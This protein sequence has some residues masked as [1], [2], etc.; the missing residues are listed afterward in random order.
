MEHEFTPGNSVHNLTDGVNRHQR[1]PTIEGNN[2][3]G[4][5]SEKMFQLSERIPDLRLARGGQPSPCITQFRTE[6]ISFTVPA[7]QVT[8]VINQQ[9]IM[10]VVTPKYWS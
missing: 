2:G 1:F 6:N 10:H 5:L 9:V 4:I 3:V 8:L 7:M